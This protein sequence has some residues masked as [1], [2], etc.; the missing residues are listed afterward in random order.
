MQR[1]IGIV[2]RPQ[3]GN[4]ANLG[5]PRRPAPV[6]HL[7]HQSVRSFDGLELMRERDCVGRRPAVGADN[8]VT[9][10]NACGR[11]RSTLLDGGDDSAR[12]AMHVD[13]QHSRRWLIQRHRYIEVRQHSA[14]RFEII[15]PHSQDIRLA[16]ARGQERDENL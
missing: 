7:D 5:G 11:R 6:P 13:D 15:E 16:A 1:L 8:L 12:D 10:R 3:S 9:G 14:R 4:G 2:N